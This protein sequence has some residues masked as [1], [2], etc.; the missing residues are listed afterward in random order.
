[1][2]KRSFEKELKLNSTQ[3]KGGASNEKKEVEKI[4]SWLTLYAYENPLISVSTAIDGDFGAATEKAVKNF[5]KHLGVAETGTVDQ[6][7]F[8]IMTKRLSNAFTSS[9]TATNLRD[10]VVKVAELHLM[11]FP[12]ELIIRRNNNSGPWVRAYMDGKDGE[13]YKW[14]MGFVQT[15]IDQAAS[16]FGKSFKDL[17]PLTYSCDTV[18]MHGIQNNKLTRYTEAR[19]NP[20]LIQKGDIFLIQKSKYDWTHTGIVIAVSGDTISTIEGNTN[21]AGS[22][23]GEA[24]LRRVRN[25]KKSKIDFFSIESLNI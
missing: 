14:C 9:V 21:F 4:Q 17:M 19:K 23:N 15:I 3:S 13:D 5:Q 22:I 25:F 12:R 18:G 16:N 11:N 7:L 20:N 24:V 2:I 6:H 8:T 10:T 1:M